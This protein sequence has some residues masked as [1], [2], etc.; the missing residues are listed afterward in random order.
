MSVL[1]VIPARYASSRL[2]GKPLLAE[3]GKPL[4]QYTYEQ[5]EK[6]AASEVLIATDDQRIFDCVTGFGGN[7]VLTSDAHETGTARVAEAAAGKDADIIINLQGDEPETDPGAIDL[8][9]DIMRHQK[10]CFAATLVCPFPAEGRS[11][12][13]SPADPSCVKAVLGQELSAGVHEALYFSRALVPWP[14]QSGGDI[15]DPS[16]FHLHLGIYAFTPES[17]PAFVSMPRSRL[18]AT[19]SLEQL[20][21]LE[22]GHKMAAGIIDA[23]P[24]GI[25]T[26][27][28]YAAFKSRQSQ[29]G[30]RA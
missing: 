29:A 18:E 13:G 9:V 4:I 30:K 11:G 14:R 26:P 12:P 21:I 6:S 10:D 25:D 19:E 3:T 20:R 1:V 24:P 17:L 22:A 27:E 2:P 16:Q 5:A 8:L 23:A 15:A 28:D 7:V